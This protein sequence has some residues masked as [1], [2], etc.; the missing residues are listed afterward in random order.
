MGK[1]DGKRR[2]AVPLLQPRSGRVL[3]DGVTAPV[4]L[5]NIGNTCFFNSVLQNLANVHALR[6]EMNR[7]HGA[8]GGVN[9]GKMVAMVRRFVDH[10]SDAS[11][12][13]KTRTI[14]PKALFAEVERAMPLFR[15][16]GQ[17]DA[18]ELLLELM[19]R[20][21]EGE[22]ARMM[23]RRRAKAHKLLELEEAKE[24]EA[25]A[26]AAAAVAVA[27]AAATRR[28]GAIESKRADASSP[29][30]APRPRTHIVGA[31]AK[32]CV[33]GS[34]A[35]A[36]PLNSTDA[37]EVA[38]AM[39]V[40]KGA[41]AAAAQSARNA[42][43]EAT[44]AKLQ[45]RATVVQSLFGGQFCK[46]YECLRCGH[47]E[48]ALMAPC[49]FLDWKVTVAEK[50]PHGAAA[51]AAANDVR[52]SAPTAR[53]AAGHSRP[54][55]NRA[56]TKAEESAS[57]NSAAARAKHA[58]GAAKT[59]AAALALAVDEASFDATKVGFIFI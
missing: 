23:K 27:A 29:A 12:S 22:A 16:R 15:G 48:T 46:R 49:S 7:L 41:V 59:A 32:K 37:I 52:G 42:R 45:P 11:R 21:H 33:P 31:W 50:L 13:A 58:A 44:Y 1:K 51:A 53:P 4:G 26:A 18:H 14:N 54:A 25:A 47:C 8:H 10:H 39:L 28:T 9:E 40:C 3:M 20:V 36:E 19:A 57:R 56:R 34:T 55:Q 5:N 35:P 43:L 2:T 30:P 6:A 17:Q 38:D 24:A